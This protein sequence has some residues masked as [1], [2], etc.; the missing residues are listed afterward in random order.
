MSLPQGLTCHASSDDCKWTSSGNPCTYGNPRIK[1][2]AGTNERC[3][4]R[5]ISSTTQPGA[6][7]AIPQSGDAGIAGVPST[8][9]FGNNDNAVGA[10]LGASGASGGFPTNTGG[11]GGN[12]TG[13]IGDGFG[14]GNQMPG[15]GGGMFGG[16]G[17][18]MGGFNG[19][20]V[21]GFNGNGA[22]G[23]GQQTRFGAQGGSAFG[24]IGGQGARGNF[25]PTGNNGFTGGQPGFGSAAPAGGNAFGSGGFNRRERQRRR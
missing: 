24:G 19:N 6:A 10:G 3:Q 14:G 13:T 1:G 25:G 11:F 8:A 4:C 20:G 9:S 16:A 2:N 18:G 15:F 23:F 21:N 12:P 22:G 17:A 5:S 7:A